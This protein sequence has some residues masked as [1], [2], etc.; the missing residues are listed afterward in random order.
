MRQHSFTILKYLRGPQRH[1][2]ALTLVTTKPWMRDIQKTLHRLGR[3]IAI[4]L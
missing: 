1:S 4:R 3:D 2:K